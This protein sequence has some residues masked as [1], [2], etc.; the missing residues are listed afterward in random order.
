[1]SSE[2]AFPKDLL[3]PLGSSG[4]PFQTAVAAGLRSGGSFEVEEEVAWQDGDGSHKF[5]DTVASLPSVRVCIECKALRNEKLVFLL[6]RYAQD[7]QTQR[8]HAIH[9]SYLATLGKP[10]VIY[11]RSDVGPL[12]HESAYCVALGKSAGESRLIEKEAQ[13]LVRAAEQYARD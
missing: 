7:S 9:L 6:P 12:S 3:S 11:A 10:T 2:P 1:M 5:L 8:V 13:P 4:F